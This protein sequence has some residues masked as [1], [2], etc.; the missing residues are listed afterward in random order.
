[1]VAVTVA[2]AGAGTLG[3]GTDGLGTDGLGTGAGAGVAGVVDTLLPPL[4]TLMD[5]LAPFW[6]ADRARRQFS[7]QVTR[8]AAMLIRCASQ[9]IL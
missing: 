7:V 8:H 3:L 9:Y 2:V 5:T 6:A 4:P 1:M